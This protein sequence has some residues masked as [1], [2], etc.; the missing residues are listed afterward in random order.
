MFQRFHQRQNAKRNSYAQQFAFADALDKINNDI[1]KC[2]ET[3]F[4]YV[5]ETFDEGEIVHGKPLLVHP[6]RITNFHIRMLP[7]FS[8]MESDTMIDFEVRVTIEFEKAEQTLLDVL[9]KK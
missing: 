3:G 2:I 7:D 9:T 6:T 1:Q 8:R 5:S 4:T